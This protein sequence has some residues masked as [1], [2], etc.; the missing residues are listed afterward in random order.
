M[1]S[2]NQMKKKLNFIRICYRSR[3]RFLIALASV[4]AL[5]LG[6]GIAG[7]DSLDFLAPWSI[8]SEFMYSWMWGT[9]SYD[10]AS[11]CG[12]GTTN[13]LRDDL[14]LPQDNQTYRVY[15]TVRPLEHHMLRVFGSV[16]ELYQSQNVLQKDLRLTQ[17]PGTTVSATTTT[18]TVLVFPAGSLVKSEMKTAQFGFGYDLDFLTGPGHAAGMQGEL[19]YIDLRLSISDGTATQVPPSPF[20]GINL[21]NPPYNGT[22]GT[23]IGYQYYNTTLDELVPTL[24][25]HA[26]AVLPFG[27]GNMFPDLTLGGYTRMNFGLW[28]NYLNY[29]DI[30]AGLQL[31]SGQKCGTRRFLIAKFGVE[32]ESILHDGQIRTGRALELKRDGLTCALE[33]VF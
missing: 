7:A 15:A 5:T 25:A 10:Q 28:P 11:C 18:N 4:F 24:G 14:G 21:T 29:V 31:N 32:H 17:L 13:Q 9:M 23:S 26:Q 33:A 22:W 3:I 1:G 16:P 27:F 12:F 30:Q 6:Q 19:R 8:G 2:Q 20:N